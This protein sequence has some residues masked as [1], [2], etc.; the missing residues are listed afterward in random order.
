[1]RYLSAPLIAVLLTTFQATA[2]PDEAPD[3]RALVE[4]ELGDGFR[5]V[6]LT[7]TTEELRRDGPGASYYGEFAAS[8]TLPVAFYHEI[9]R[10]EGYILVGQLL[11]RGEIVPAFGHVVAVYGDDGWTVEINVLDLQ[12]PGGRPFSEF[13]SPGTVVLE[14]GTNLVDRFQ[15]QR[16]VALQDAEVLRVQDLRIEDAETAALLAR[17]LADVEARDASLAESLAALERS[18]A[19]EAETAAALALVQSDLGKARSVAEADAAVIRELLAQAESARAELDAKEA[20]RLA[21]AAIAEALRERLNNSQAEAARLAADR[22]RL[23]NDVA[24]L[25]DVEADAEGLRAE[26]AA[27]LAARTAAGDRLRDAE[28]DAAGLREKLAAALAARLAAEDASASALSAR[29]RERLLLETANRRLAEEREISAKAQ[30]EVALLNAQVAALRDQ[31]AELS[32]LLDSAEERDR[33]AGVRIQELGSRLNRALAQVA[34]EQRRR[35]E[36]ERQRAEMEAAEAERLRREKEALGEEVVDLAAYR[37]EFFGTLRRVLGDREGVRIVGD[38]FLFPSEVLFA[39]GSAT[40]LPEG[41]ASI[42]E[43]AEILEEVA[44]EIPPNLDWV[45][46]VDGHT[47]NAPVTNGGAFADNWELSAGRALSVVKYMTGT[48]GFPAERLAAAGFSEFRPVNPENSDAA[49]AQN[50][51]IELKL[52]ER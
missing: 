16:E 37:S 29:D 48:L 11:E 1:M 43:V 6:D 26:L 36:A 39:S 2:N 45:L 9:G 30:R 51:R 21:E 52:T 47:D 35:A 34:A 19:A 32:A 23:Q 33:A 50:R 27:A 8:V 46:R 25:R 3:I 13:R 12:L 38:R 44:D 49:R 4:S 7:L 40:L 15:T 22:D 10:G 28:A 41:Q 18:E 17:A 5:V 20:A 24:T 14:A 31:L 42:A